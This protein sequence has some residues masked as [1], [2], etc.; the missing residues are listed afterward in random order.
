GLRPGAGRRGRQLRA[1]AGSPAR[2]HGRRAAGRDGRPP[3]RR[4]RVV[5]VELTAIPNA[6]RSQ[7]TGRDYGAAEA[8]LGDAPVPAA[9]DLRRPWHPIADQGETASCV[10]W[11]VADSCLRWQL[12]EAGRLDPEQRLSARYVWM[13]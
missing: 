1:R 11:S 2:H 13:S 6:R 5:A 10:G 7:G 8:N 9:I 4:R 12:V 3:P